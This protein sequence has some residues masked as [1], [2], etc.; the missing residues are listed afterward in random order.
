MKALAGSG[1]VIGCGVNPPP[2]GARI[3]GLF[4]YRKNSLNVTCVVLRRVKVSVFMP[5]I[6]STSTGCVSFQ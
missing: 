5:L 6:S 4:V 2:G 3:E 1:G